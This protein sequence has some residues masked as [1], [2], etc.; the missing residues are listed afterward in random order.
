MHGLGG[1]I[2]LQAGDAS[3]GHAQRFASTRAWRGGDRREQ[4][5]GHESA[6][7]WVTVETAADDEF[8]LSA[9][10]RKARPALGP[11]RTDTSRGGNGTVGDG[12]RV[13]RR[14]WASS[15][16]PEWTRAP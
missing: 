1:E 9:Y 13:E 12:G 16:R 15:T 8:G 14:S 10:P 6:P 5:S 11:N 4:P 2:V 3:D 7:R